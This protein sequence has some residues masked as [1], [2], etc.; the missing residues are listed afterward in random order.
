MT[1][2]VAFPELTE[3]QRRVHRAGEALHRDGASP[4]GALD[5]LAALV[6]DR[7]WERVADVR[8]TSFAG[9]F[10][11]F[12]QAKP[13]YGL[14]Y[15]P[16]Q[17]PKI[18]TLRHPHESVDRVADRMAA[19]REAVRALL[20]AEV[21][22]AAAHG[23]IGRGANRVRGTHSIGNADRVERVVA[24]LKRDAPDVAE[25]V[26]AG[27]L[28]PNAAAREM[29]WRRPRIVVSTPERVAEALRRT[30]PPEDLAR[31]IALLGK[32]D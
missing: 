2:Q 20:L 17:L 4:A 16:E 3:E 13:P 5:L 18:L 10:R 28:S 7:T 11:D 6:E 31:L 15:D 23:E 19:M 30:M 32:I 14:G 12:V 29:G 24:R 8:G 27:D 9:R 22:S 26:V 25:R 1:R 21:P